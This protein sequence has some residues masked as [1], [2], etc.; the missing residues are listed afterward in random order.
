[1]VA[2]IPRE[3]DA[4]TTSTTGEEAPLAGAGEFESGELEGIHRIACH[5][6]GIG[7]RA[8]IFGELSER[9]YALAH[10]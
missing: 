3:R 2:L 1:V 7:R 9:G 10:T 4:L 6:G 8:E 5:V